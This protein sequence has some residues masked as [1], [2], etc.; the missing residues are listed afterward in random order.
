LNESRGYTIEKIAI[1]TGIPSTTVY[2]IIS[3][4]LKMKKKLAKWVPYKLNEDQ[5]YFRS[6][7]CYNNL[8]TCRRNPNTI[9]RTIA[10]DESWIFL[11]TAPKGKDKK[12]W[13]T[14]EEPRPT[15]VSENIHN[16]KRILIMAMDYNGI[17]FWKLLGEKQY[18]DSRAYYDFI[19][20]YI[21][22]CINYK[23]GPNPIIL[24]DNARP[25]KSKLVANLLEANKIHKWIHPPYSPDLHPCD[26]NCFGPLKRRLSHYKCNGWNQ[27]EEAIEEICRIGINNGLFQRVKKLP[28]RWELVVEKNGVYI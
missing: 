11:Y 2:R 1:E 16:S 7:V 22:N 8:L 27:V 3:Q 28:D 5:T 26:Y 9:K 10:I 18:C 25:H 17:A 21:V 24:H 6:E 23:N 19:N 15:I 4:V 14:N 20:E 12:I 13:V